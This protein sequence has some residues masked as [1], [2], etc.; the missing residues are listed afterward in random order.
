MPSCLSHFWHDENGAVLLTE[1]CLLATILIIAAIPMLLSL[2]RQVEPA[3][4][5]SSQELR[6]DL[7]AG[8]PR[9]G[10]G[11]PHWAAFRARHLRP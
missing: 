2:R 3:Q 11:G 9:G 10:D 6:W 8:S 4:M 7:P 1:W 5:V